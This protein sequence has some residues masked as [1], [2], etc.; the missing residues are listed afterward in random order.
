MTNNLD[1]GNR[2]RKLGHM[3]AT[4]L[5]EEPSPTRIRH[6]YNC[7]ANSLFHNILPASASESI[8]CASASYAVGCN[9]KKT[10]I[11]PDRA[12]K[13]LLSELGFVAHR[14]ADN[15][16]LSNILHVTP[17]KKSRFC[18]PTHPSHRRN[19]KK[20][21]TLLNLQ[22]R[23]QPDSLFRNILPVT[24]TESRFCVPTPRHP[25][26][27][28]ENRDFARSSQKKLHDPSRIK[29]KQ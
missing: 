8:F 2:K 15:S 9:L 1:R 16:L 17:G 22:I 10:S 3:R 11:L 18:K 23:M 20:T 14:C 7:Q 28:E 29:Y 6:S 26:Q 13:R 21:N 4:T 24:P 5:R 19:F 12:Q 25:V 27:L